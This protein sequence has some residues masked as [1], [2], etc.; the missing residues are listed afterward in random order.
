VLNQYPIDSYLGDAGLLRSRKAGNWLG[1]ASL[2]FSL[3]P[4]GYLLIGV[5][6]LHVDPF[7]HL[8]QL[9]Y[10]AYSL[11]IWGAV[12]SS[13]LALA[14]GLLGSRLWFIVTLGAAMD[15]LMLLLFSP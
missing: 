7:P 4:I 9:A 3:T 11:L 6:G 5:Y 14:A 1:F 15:V 13:V 8:S 2:G 12:V 10:I